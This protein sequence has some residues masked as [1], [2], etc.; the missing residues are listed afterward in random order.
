M[1]LYQPGSLQNYS[2]LRLSCIVA[3]IM[4][5]EKM[6]NTKKHPPQMSMPTLHD[7]TPNIEAIHIDCMTGL[8]F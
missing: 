4:Y 1:D 7:E 3:Y 8:M 6:K 5:Y 2:L